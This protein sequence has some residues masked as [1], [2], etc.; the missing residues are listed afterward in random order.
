NNN[1]ENYQMSTK[2]MSIE[3]NNKEPVDKYNKESVDKYKEKAK[4][5]TDKIVNKISY[6]DDIRRNEIAVD[7]SSNVRFITFGLF[8]LIG[9]IVVIY[10]ILVAVGADTA[11]QSANVFFV[12]TILSISILVGTLVYRIGLSK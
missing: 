10:A 11:I 8:T 1:G 4:S 12:V 5:F 3:N 2:S 9:F 6:I 7:N